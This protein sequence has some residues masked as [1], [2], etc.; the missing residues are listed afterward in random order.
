MREQEVECFAWAIGCEN[1]RIQV[2][3]LIRGVP[4]RAQWIA[5]NV[6]LI[7]GSGDYS[8][9]M[10]L[11]WQDRAFDLLR[12]L[13]QASKPTFGSCWGFQALVR[14]MG[15]TVV[16][17]PLHAELG[18]CRCYL[19][20][21]GR[22]DPIFAPCGEHFRVYMGHEDRAD[23]LPEDAICLTS[24]DQVAYQAIRFRDKPIY[25]AQFHVEL[26]RRTFLQRIET[27]PKYVQQITGQTFSDFAATCP[28]IPDLRAVLQRFVLATT[29]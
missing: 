16:H 4:S 7:G 14:A 6:V 10:S 29:F 1:D 22:R 17:D 23:V 28:S 24:T 8:T 25:A 3:D 9:T 15:G 27:Y 18:V 13:H 5:C 20:E 26:H 2:C 12:D 21:S 11:P 19:T